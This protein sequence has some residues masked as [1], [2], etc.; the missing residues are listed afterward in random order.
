[1]IGAVVLGLGLVSCQV[2]ERPLEPES[3]PEAAQQLTFESLRLHQADKNGQ[4]VW[5]LQADKA[6]ADV[7]TRQV[8]AQQVVG[9]IYAQ[10][11][12]RYRVKAAQATVQEAQETL[13]VEGEI[14]AEDIQ[15]RTVIKARLLVWRPAQKEILLKG[16][17]EFRQ[18]KLQVKAQEAIIRLR[19]NRLS[20]RQQVQVTNQK[21]ALRISGEAL[22][23]QWRE[24]LVQALQPVQIVYTPEQLVVKAGG[25]QM[26]FPRQVL[27]LSQGVEAVHQR[28]RLRAQTVEWR[29]E[30]QEVTASGNVFY[31][32]T[33]PPL[34][35]AG[36]QAEGNLAMRQIRVTRARTQVIPE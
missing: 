22:D 30:R 3:S 25:G 1:M 34:T 13:T 4:T 18:P 27:R 17:L 33:D 12:P 11:K 8:T 36:A 10:G 9:D 14:T 23:W 5:K 31:T 19:D 28:G 35:V 7:Q 26:D 32:Q 15:D 16:N 2:P 24:G 6:V 29:I 21:P 20:L